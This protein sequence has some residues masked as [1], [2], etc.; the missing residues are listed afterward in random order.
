MSEDGEKDEKAIAIEKLINPVTQWQ[1]VDSSVDFDVMCHV[2]TVPHDSMQFNANLM[3]C[4][5]SSGISIFFCRLQG[6]KGR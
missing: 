5:A 4:T 3:N 6:C 1:V 2:S